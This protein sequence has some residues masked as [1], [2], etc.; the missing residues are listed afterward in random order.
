MRC[1]ASVGVWV[2]V[3]IPAARKKSARVSRR[4]GYVPRQTCGPSVQVNTCGNPHERTSCS[5]SRC[6]LVVIVDYVVQGGR[7]K[8]L[9]RVVGAFT[10]NR[11][12][13][14]AESRGRAF[15]RRSADGFNEGKNQVTI[16]PRGFPKSY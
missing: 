9:L 16:Q 6:D 15:P 4:R 1:Q 13:L 11:F 5:A 7:E 14:P 12:S 2:I 8:V 10:K 3:G